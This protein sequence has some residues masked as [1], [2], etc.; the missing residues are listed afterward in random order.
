MI[1]ARAATVQVVGRASRL[2]PRRLALEPTDAGETPVLLPGTKGA[3]R[4]RR[5]RFS[6]AAAPSCWLAAAMLAAGATAPA[7]DALRDSLAGDAAA[8]AQRRGEMDT[9]YTI[10]QGDFRMLMTPS[11]ELDWN[12]NINITSSGQL[13]DYIVRPMV[14]LS[15][16]YPLTY[17]NVLRLNTSLGYDCYLEHPNYSGV[18]V[19]SGS[20]LSFDTYIK[21]FRIN[22]HD[23]FQYTRDAAGLAAVAA[24][25]YYGGLDNFAGVSATWDLED[26]VL[27]LGYDHENFLAS[28]AQFDYLN[29]ASEL[30]VSRAGFRVN[31]ALTAGV[32]GSGSI[33]TYDQSIILN[34]SIGY[35]AGLY[36]DWHPGHYTDVQLRGGYTEYSFDQTG[37]VAAPANA[38]GWYVGLTANQ[39]I[40]EA[41]SYSISAGHEIILGLQANTV[42]DWYFRPTI[43]WKFMKDLTF[44]TSAGYEHGTQLLA[45]Q[46]AASESYDW[47]W[48]GLGANYGLTKRL[49]LGLT[50]RLTERFSD[51]AE[52]GYAQNIVGLRLS[53][54]LQ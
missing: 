39:D 14:D 51:V 30:L 18:R 10:K 33:N 38:N 46:T 6:R 5:R 22:V 36:G 40:T 8:E 16:S 13:Q 9:A 26:V 42:E 21:D 2:S 37:P 19:F 44:N 41:I 25:G 28:N 1:L 3:N 45:T 53:Y 24:T 43:N 15:L 48:V 52:R 17:W 49:M 20:M 4:A 12:D 23:R 47:F 50:Y 7:Q 34:N 54:L 27:S 35:S 31:P 29:R 32:E 11:L